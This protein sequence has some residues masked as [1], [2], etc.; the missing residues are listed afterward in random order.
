MGT[1]IVYVGEAESVWVPALDA[2]VL[3]GE[4]I[5]VNDDEVAASLLEQPENWALEGAAP[6]SP[7]KPSKPRRGAVDDTTPDDPG[8][9][10]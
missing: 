10:D 3:A 9:E 6:P 7:K 8:Q 2:V 5:V 1:T 4:P